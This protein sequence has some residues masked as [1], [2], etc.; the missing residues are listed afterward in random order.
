MSMLEDYI[1][2]LENYEDIS[3]FNYVDLILL[4]SELKAYRERMRIGDIKVDTQST[5]RIDYFSEQLQKE[6]E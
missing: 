3:P 1:N 4:L 5:R 2:K 6:R